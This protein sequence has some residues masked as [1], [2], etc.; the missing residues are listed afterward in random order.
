MRKKTVL[1]I[2]LSFAALCATG[3]LLYYSKLGENEMSDLYTGLIGNFQTADW[4]RWPTKWILGFAGIGMAFY[5]F[6]TW[7]SNAK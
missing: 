7:Y 5:A 4:R 1:V 6:K 2:A 3:I